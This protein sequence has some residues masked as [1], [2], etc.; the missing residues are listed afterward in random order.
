MLPPSICQSV[1]NWAWVLSPF[2][3]A[4]INCPHSTRFPT[5]ML[6]LSPQLLKDIPLSYVALLFPSGDRDKHAIRRNPPKRCDC[7]LPQ[8]LPHFSALLYKET[9]EEMSMMCLQLISV[10]P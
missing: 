8:P 4:G 5:C 9:P 10:L 6:H 2:L 3:L 7:P 1:S